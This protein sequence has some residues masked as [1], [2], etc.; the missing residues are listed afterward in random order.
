MKAITT[1][2]WIEIVR[3]NHDDR[4]DY[5]ETKYNGRGK[6]VKIFCNK[7]G[8]FE[9]KENS[10]RYGSNCPYCERE[11]FRK[12]RLEYFIKTSNE[13]H[14]F[15]YDYSQVEYVNNSTNVKIICPIHGVFHQK[16][17]KH[18]IGQGCPKCAKNFKR[19]L[20]YFI[21][22]SRLVHG[23]KYDYSK[24]EYKNMNTKVCIVCKK[25]GEFWQTPKNH[26][27]HMECCPKC[28]SSILEKEVRVFLTEK[29][30]S[31][32][33]QKKFKWLKRQRLDFYLPEY[34]IA[35]EC[36]GE[37]HFKPIEVFGGEK[38]FEY[39]RQMDLKKEEL[40]IENGVE[41][42]YYANC[43]VEKDLYHEIYFDKGVMLNDIYKKQK[44]QI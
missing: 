43:E 4:Y 9:M 21:E 32:E 25:H 35:I 5:S 24:V 11:K 38:R 41:V 3:K 2:E 22:K 29:G 26:I 30:I 15:K 36:Q 31:F 13:V 27:Y 17:D 44:R 18:I 37:Q 20:E 10:F 14:G 42:Y 19:D 23:N 6:K 34:N 33:E 16:P 12:E 39:R 1:E 40:C 7:H 28:Q 8:F